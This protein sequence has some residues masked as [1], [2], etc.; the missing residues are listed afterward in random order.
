MPTDALHTRIAAVLARF[1]C[2]DECGMDFDNGLACPT[3]VR[4][5]LPE[6]DA[7]IRELR[8]HVV[9]VG[10][11]QTVIKGSYPKPLEESDV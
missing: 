11:F 9:T 3:C 6:A 2:E 10:D 5:S 1:L 7:V 8:L 4:R